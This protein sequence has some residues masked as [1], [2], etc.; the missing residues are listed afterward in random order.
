M[1]LDHLA[2]DIFLLMLNLS[3]L[4]SAE[5]ILEVFLEAM[6]H[7]QQAIQLRIAQDGDTETGVGERVAIATMHYT[8]GNVWLEPA[9][10]A[11]APEVLGLVRNA[12]KMLALVLENR[13]QAQALADENL[14]LEEAVQARTEELLQTNIQ[15]R[16][17][18]AER[19]HAEE[20]QRY[21]QGLLQ[22]IINSLP[23]ALI[24]LNATG[25]ILNWN[26]TAAQLTGQAL[27]GKQGQRLWQVCPELAHYQGL[28]EEV[29][30]SQQAISR[31][32]EPW[33][34]GNALAHRDITVFPLTANGLTGAVLRIE[35]VTQR[36]RLEEAAFLTTKMVSMGRLAAGMAH[37]INNPLGAIMQ[38]AQILQRAFD[39]NNTHTLNL[40]DR[41]NL[42]PE[43]IACYLEERGLYEYLEGIRTA[44]ARAAKI[45]EDLLYFSHDQAMD[46]SMYD[47]NALVNQTLDLAKTDYD[48]RT[49]YDFRNLGLV[50]EFAPDLP[51]VACDGAQIQQVILNLVRNAAQAMTE[52]SQSSTSSA[53]HPML[54]LRTQHR[55]HAIYIEVEDNG[56]GIS[57]TVKKHLFE[58]FF[59]TKDV[60]SGTGLGLWV[61]WSIVVER[62]HGQIYAETGNDGGARFVVALPIQG[63]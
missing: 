61:C 56:P 30:R 39:L 28:F 43:K 32:R 35:D 46:F 2:H 22:N 44:G 33:L 31:P 27:E 21:L 7:A 49:R 3:Q 10:P 16:V 50:C 23:A 54:T 8:F 62:H 34:H 6:N 5:R 45:I 59:T 63:F 42:E 11:P 20:Q 4:R 36:V 12:L 52:K 53:Y 60:G 14:R 37:E 29:I 15:L 9:T 51:Q 40:L 41:C 25:H 18:I 55:E 47:L 58:P 1:I 19:E 24:T 48:L 26:L 17:E 38:G 57:E 13:A